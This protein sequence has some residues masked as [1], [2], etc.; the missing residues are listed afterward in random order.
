MG[1]IKFAH[2]NFTGSSS[3][4]KKIFFDRTLGCGIPKAASA[5]RGG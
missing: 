1:F 3:P 5:R 4:C 2:K